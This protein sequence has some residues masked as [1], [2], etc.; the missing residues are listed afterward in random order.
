MAGAG[1]HGGPDI[2]TLEA[3]CQMYNKKQREKKSRNEL[4]NS[5]RNADT[6]MAMLSRIGLMRKENWPTLRV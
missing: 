5:L 1:A 2:R 6:G 4:T 3:K